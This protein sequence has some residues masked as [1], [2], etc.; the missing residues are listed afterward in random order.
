MSELTQNYAFQELRRAA[1]AKQRLLENLKQLE[2]VATSTAGP[3]VAASLAAR[4]AIRSAP[5]VS[6]AAVCLAG[7]M[8]GRRPSRRRFPE[9]PQ[10]QDPQSGHIY[11]RNPIWAGLAGAGLQLLVDRLTGWVHA[12]RFEPHE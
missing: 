1:R 5:I 10:S 9:H 8:V 12:D 4:R 11:Q 6:V 7:Y 2:S 3:A